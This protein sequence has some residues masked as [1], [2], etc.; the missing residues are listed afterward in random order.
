MHQLTGVFLNLI[1]KNTFPIFPF[2]QLKRL[3][4]VVCLKYLALGTQNRFTKTFTLFLWRQLPAAGKNLTI[5]LELSNYE[6]NFKGRKIIL[7][8]QPSKRYKQN[9]FLQ[10]S[11]LCVCVLGHLSFYFIGK[12]ECVSGITHQAHGYSNMGFI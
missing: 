6:Q 9:L 4:E 2:G 5:A 11:A 8:S 10:L 3:E 12:D 1:S 7:Y